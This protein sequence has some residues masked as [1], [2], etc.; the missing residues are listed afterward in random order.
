MVGKVPSTSSYRSASLPRAAP[1]PPSSIERGRFFIKP[2]RS[3]KLVETAGLSSTPKASIYLSADSRIFFRSV[4]PIL[5]PTV[6]S[7]EW[8]DKKLD[9]HEHKKVSPTKV[10]V[11]NSITIAQECS[12]GALGQLFIDLGQRLLESAVQAL[13]QHNTLPVIVLMFLLHDCAQR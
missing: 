10:N 6:K 5:G 13:S 3:R 12:V 8:R 7:T 11:Q 1:S 2:I 4:L 9:D